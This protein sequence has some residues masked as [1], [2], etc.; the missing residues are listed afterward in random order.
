MVSLR[1]KGLFP[2]GGKIEA[3][4]T[5]A[6]FGIKWIAFEEQLRSVLGHYLAVLANERSS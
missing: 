5:Q 1:E 3:S 4:K 2:L 6:A